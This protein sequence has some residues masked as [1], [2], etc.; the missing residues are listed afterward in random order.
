MELRDYL[1]FT[2]TTV[3]EFAKKLQVSRSYITKL[4]AGNYPAS[5]LVAKQ[6]EEITGGEVTVEDVSKTRYVKSKRMDKKDHISKTNVS[7]TLLKKTILDFFEY[8]NLQS[9]GGVERTKEF[10]VMLD[11]FVE[12]TMQ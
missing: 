1:Y 4:L 10:G 6:I 8:L 9:C 11:E 7:P 2:R 5:R 3:T 12:K